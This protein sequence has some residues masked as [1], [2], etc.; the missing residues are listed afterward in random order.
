MFGSLKQGSVCYILIK[1]EKTVL[2]IGQVE[3]VSNPTPKYPTFNPSIPFGSQQETVI[4][5]K[6]KYGEEVMEFQKIPTNL[7]IFSYPNAVLSD[8]KEAILS[9]VENMIQTSQQIVSSV[10]YHKSIIENCDEILKQLNPQFA[11]DKQQE[12][13]IGS[14]ETE[15][16]SLKGDLFDIKN[17]LKSLLSE[18][19]G[20]NK[21]KTNSKT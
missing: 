15:V 21:Q 17:D 18:L 2:K 19:N 9:E 10:D 12:E 16:K 5:A 7:E 8:K 3:S 11:K 13:K 14:L 20:S 4:D 6:I 1:G